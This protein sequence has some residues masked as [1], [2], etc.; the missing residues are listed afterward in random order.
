MRIVMTVVLSLVL[1]TAAFADAGDLDSNFST[2]GFET[3]DIEGITQRDHVY[4]SQFDSEGRLILV[5]ASYQSATGDE[6]FL[7]M[8]FT[9]AGELDTSFSSDGIATFDFHGKED[10]AYAFAFDSNNKIV[11]AGYATDA[12]QDFGVIRLNADGS[13]DT[14]FNPT[15]AVASGNPVDAGQMRFSPDATCLNEW[16]RGVAVEADDQIV[17][18]GYCQ[19]TGASN[20]HQFAFARLYANGTV[21]SD[22]VYDPSADHDRIY[23]LVLDSSE[24]LIVAA[25]VHNG[26]N[27]DFAVAR[28]DSNFNLDTAGFNAPFGMVT[29]DFDSGNDRAFALTLDADER[30]VPIGYAYATNGATS[31]NDFLV[32]RLNTDG[33][34]DSD[35]NGVGYNTFDFP[36][37]GSD[38]GVAVALDNQGRILVGGQSHSNAKAATNFAMIRVLE[39]GLIDEDFG[40]YGYVVTPIGPSTDFASA[41]TIDANQGIWLSGSS[42]SQ[43]GTNVYSDVALA[44]YNGTT[45]GNG[46]FETGESCDDGNADETD[47]C[48]STCE[49][50][51]CG[52]GYTQA[53]VEVCDDG[54]SDETDTCL[55]SCVF[56][57]CGDGFTQTANNEECDDGNTDD[58]DGCSATCQDEPTPNV[59]G[60]GS[61][62]SGEECDDGNTDD[63]DGCS[64][65]CLIETAGNSNSGTNST[66]TP[67]ST[68]ATETTDTTGTG[69][70]SAT[71]NATPSLGGSGCQLQPSAPFTIGFILPSLCLILSL[72]W[73]RRFELR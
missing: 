66:E 2:N 43:A 58:E 25:E 60:N 64:S 27:L 13:L 20:R 44:K 31:S 72:L 29:K 11:V 49:I 65:S 28:F 22:A 24:N 14:T 63:D 41:I 32:G 1:S 7:V 45:C 30:I 67:D 57:S 18:A 71:N 19:N 47:S 51:S 36:D 42:Y 50:A 69:T 16:A 53:G 62:E 5:G 4:A 34:W 39:T 8:R 35:F 21:E 40:A 48:L 15:G 70:S 6:D 26:S 37:G 12:N 9:A 46:I 33:S 55:S 61:I 10:F 38:L 56:A 3:Y 73:R 68:D 54:N 59:C 52:D 17:V 23:A